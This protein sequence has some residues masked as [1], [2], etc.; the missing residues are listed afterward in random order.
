MKRVLQRGLQ[1]GLQG[2]S[3]APERLLRAGF[4]DPPRSDRGIE[5]D[6]RTH[7]LLSLARRA[8]IGE[9]HELPPAK[10]RR[11]F[12][13]NGALLDLPATPLAEQRDFELPG[14]AGPLQARLY[15]PQP[16]PRQPSS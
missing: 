6:L 10:A 7:V 4:G 12:E 1:R 11:H 13:A 9:I 16:R 15:R 5:Q 8:G 3:G 14:P 2:L